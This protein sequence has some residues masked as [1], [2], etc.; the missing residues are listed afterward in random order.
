MR[1]AV[2]AVC[3]FL[4]GGSG[5]VFETLWTRKLTHVFGSTTLSVASV[6]TAFMGGLALGSFLLGRHLA[7]RVRRPILWYAAIE[8]LVGLWG[9]GIPLV[10]DHLYPHLNALLWNHFEPGYFAFSFLRFLFVVLILLPP[11]TLM[12]ATLPL[13]ARHFVT[14]EAE[15]RRVG[16]RV[17]LLYAINTTGAIGG[18]FLAGFVLLPGV[19]FA[20]TNGIA[21]GANLALCAAVLAAFLLLPAAR[22]PAAILVSEPEEEAAARARD[23]AGSAPG[24]DLEFP[25]ARFDPA[26][27]EPIAGRRARAIALVAFGISGFASMNY[28]VAWNRVLS[29]VIGSSVYSFTIILLSFLVGIAGGSSLA[30]LALRRIRNPIPWLGATQLWIGLTGAAA[31]YFADDFPYLFAWLVDRLGAVSPGGASVG[32]V[33]AVGFAVSSLAILPATLGMGATFPLTVRICATG[34]D[35]VGRDVGTLYAANTLGAILGSFASA[36]LLVPGFSALSQAAVGRG[37]GLQLSIGFS[38][39][40]NLALATVLFA[41]TPDRYRGDD[42]PRAGLRVFRWS[43]ATFVPMLALLVGSLT[44]VQG[45]TWAPDRMATGSFR[46]AYL[47]STLHGRHGSDVLYH[48]DGIST[49][50]TVQ[51]WG[52]HVALKN[53][54]KVDASNGDDMPTQVMVAALPIL[55]HPRGPEGLRVAIVGFGSGVSVGTALGFPVARVDVVELEPSVIEAA[56]FF[57]RE[58]LLAYPADRGPG[59]DGPPQPLQP[60]PRLRILSNDGRNFLA[61]TPDRYDVV[62]SEPSNPWIT[63]VSNL[64]TLD[65]FRA[66]RQALA[67]QGIFCQWVQLYELSPGTVRSI[68]R[69]F[70]LAFPHVQ[71]FSAA[72]SSADTILLGSLDP[73]DPRIRPL[74]LRFAEPTLADVLSYDRTSL[75]AADDIVARRLFASRDEVLAWT[76]GAA[77]NTDDNAYVEFQA[78][79]DLI[80]Y[81]A[82]SP[83]TFREIYGPDWRFGRI[84]LEALRRIGNDFESPEAA[85][86]AVYGM[87]EALLRAGRTRWAADLALEAALDPAVSLAPDE[88][89]ASDLLRAVRAGRPNAAERRT[90][91]LLAATIAAA[92][93]PAAGDLRIAAST[94]APAG[95]PRRPAAAA[96]IV[97][98]ARAR[99]AAAFSAPPAAFRLALLRDALEDEIALRKPPI[100]SRLPESWKP[101]L[102]SVREPE[103]RTVLRA[104]VDGGLD[105]LV[106]PLPDGRSPIA[107]AASRIAGPWAAD[108]PRDADAHV[109][110][111]LRQSA[112]LEAGRGAS[113]GADVRLATLAL[114]PQPWS[115]DEFVR[116]L[117]ELVLWDAAT[118]DPDERWATAGRMEKLGRVARARRALLEEGDPWTE[119]HGPVLPD[120]ALVAAAVPWRPDVGE[121]EDPAAAYEALLSDL[122]RHDADAAR[123][124]RARF[125]DAARESGALSAAEWA[126]PE[127]V[128]VTAIGRALLLS[129]RHEEAWETL[130]SVLLPEPTAP[131]RRSLPYLAARAVWLRRTGAAAAE[132]A[133]TPEA[134]LHDDWL[135]ACR[136]MDRWARAGG[137]GPDRLLAE[138]IPTLERISTGVFPYL[139]LV[140]EDRVGTW[141]DDRD[142]ADRYDRRGI[143]RAFLDADF[144]K[145]DRLLAGAANAALLPPAEA[146]I[147]PV[148]EDP[149]LG[150]FASVAGGLEAL[151]LFDALHG[152][153]RGDPPVGEADLGNGLDRFETEAGLPERLAR[154]RDAPPYRFL[155]ARRR[156]GTGDDE[157]MRR[158]FGPAI[159]SP[160]GA[161]S[162]LAR[163]LANSVTA[164]YH[165]AR[166]TAGCGRTSCRFVAGPALERA[167]ALAGTLTTGREILFWQLDYRDPYRSAEVPWIDLPT[168]EVRGGEGR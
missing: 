152:L 65:H 109:R 76:D 69:T 161:N 91:E 11:T 167:L 25:S 13:L 119:A 22:A 153:R 44:F 116:V 141:F 82:E 28:Q 144:A 118:A 142:L 27:A 6:L 8:G 45:W 131:A 66:A 24:D 61:S 40:L 138:G 114:R 124:D 62:V 129:G 162:P 134:D 79:R 117:P 94:Y 5:L 49:T 102:A 123:R 108:V 126:V 135:L 48:F 73:I 7:D 60:E 12:G 140:Q 85:T 77:V 17:G 164:R 19:G 122:A 70:A 154:L 59:D 68:L 88:M 147:D 54:G 47:H 107:W 137:N 30:S 71:V 21:A 32:T 101:L 96:W 145:L 14:T 72:P 159:D 92:A 38:I 37:Y 34:R 26:G 99:H 163:L 168:L 64:F 18:T 75:A 165:L 23:D 130:S 139:P 36:F 155:A 33:M 84:D 78:P 103:V 31:Y 93:E 46:L 35:R 67:P 16:S 1:N 42:G 136:L 52:D 151:L 125:L 74:R 133:A 95:A 128:V 63:G 10:I 120:P 9:L 112:I 97:A 4:S 57:R 106:R 166:L 146:E 41:A 158:V 115:S 104:V 148:D 29:M 86:R 50:V 83:P 149:A 3:F 81:A 51:R 89:Q 150:P 55:V 105:A 39:L 110:R 157:A 132:I 56:W 20:W 127:S 113:A 43:A 87:V 111:L 80:R 2:V 143:G 121:P 160:P 100:A 156:Y 90:A 58:N 98:G 15:M 53:N